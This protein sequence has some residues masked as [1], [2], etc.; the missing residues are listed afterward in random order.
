MPYHMLVNGPLTAAMISAFSV[1]GLAGTVKLADMAAPDSGI[2]APF[3]LV[4]CKA[5]DC[6]LV[7]KGHDGQ[8]H[9]MNITI[10]PCRSSW[11]LPIPVRHN[12][13]SAQA[14]DET[15]TN[16]V[17]LASVWPFEAHQDPEDRQF[18]K[19]QSRLAQLP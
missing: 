4:A 14:V 3:S 13:F 1:F 17:C 2:S 8:S 9:G 11:S 6:S 18:R 7:L 19:D 15:G 12:P 16:K 10:S 5:P